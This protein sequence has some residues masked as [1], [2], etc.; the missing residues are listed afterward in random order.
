[1]IN[2]MA[3]DYGDD[4]APNPQGQMGTYAI[5]SAQS[6]YSQLRNLYGPG[7]LPSQL[8]GKIGVTPLIGTNDPPDEV[9]GPSDAKQLLAF[10]K[11]VGLGE[12]SMW[13][14]G[15]DNSYGFSSIFKPFTNYR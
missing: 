12:V 10:A 9:F 2:V 11:K 1:M 7:T 15:T 8:W 4:A 14:L 3:M 6:T 13:S 5:D